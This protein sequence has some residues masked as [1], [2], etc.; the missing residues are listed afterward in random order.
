MLSGCVISWFNVMD[1]GRI[2]DHAGVPVICVTY[3][4]SEGLDEDIRHY[5]PGDTARLAAYEKL[6][7]RLPVELRGG[8]MCFI[9]SWGISPEDAG[10]LCRDFTLEGKIPEPLRVARLCARRASA[11]F[12][13]DVSR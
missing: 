8:G 7:P 4:D 9:R 10:T 1:P 6:G 5:F 2:A 13:D 12:P 3:E 11:I